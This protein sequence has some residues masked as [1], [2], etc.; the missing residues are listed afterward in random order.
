MSTQLQ[1]VSRAADP[2]LARYLKIV[3]SQPRLDAD[4]ERRLALAYRDGDA[5]AGERLVLSNL[6]IVVKIAFRYHSRMGQLV[7]LVQEGN[8]GLLR[9]LEK[10]DPSRNVPFSAYARFW[11]RAMVLRYLMENH[12]LASSANTR[13]GRRLFW[14]L[15]RERQRLELDGETATPAR[16]ARALGATE[17]EVI[18]VS[19]LGA[20]ELSIDDA[21]ADGGRAWLDILPDTTALD[22]ETQVDR[23]RMLETVRTGVAAFAHGLGERDRRIL[24]ARIT[25]EDPV[26]LGVLS[27]ELGVSRERVRQLEARIRSRLGEALAV[28][29]FPG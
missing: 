22:P 23:R 16:L 26:T 3:R 27:E 15:A 4:E 12:H 11:V 8:V 28:D 25:S 17:G 24:E 21:G 29:A 6:D 2:E 18:A 19:R 13:E 20:R 14:E 1:H 9:A 7:D 5:G 10:Y